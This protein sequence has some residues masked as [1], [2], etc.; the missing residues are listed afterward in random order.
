MASSDSVCIVHPKPS[1]SYGDACRIFDTAVQAPGQT[2]VVDLRNAEYATTSA[3]ARLVL[4]RRALLQEGRDLYLKG[5]RDRTATIYQIS[6][7]D[8]VLPTRR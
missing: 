1:F 8:Q 2:V 4:L 6:R 3:F 5:L 7:L